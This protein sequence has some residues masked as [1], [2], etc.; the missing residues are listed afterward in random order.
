MTFFCPAYH[1]NVFHVNLNTIFKTEIWRRC[2]IK[3]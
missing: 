2:L 3:E 1:T